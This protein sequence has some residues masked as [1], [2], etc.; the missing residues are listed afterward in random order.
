[1]PAPLKTSVHDDD[2]NEPT[3]YFSKPS[4][5]SVETLPYPATVVEVCSETLLAIAC[6]NATSIREPT[7]VK[8]IHTIRILF[9]YFTSHIAHALFQFFNLGN[10]TWR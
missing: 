3:E 4:E 8:R 7:S 9:I 1:V 10:E 2:G 5:N 6:E